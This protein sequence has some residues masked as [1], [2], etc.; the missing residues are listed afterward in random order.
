MSVELP[1]IPRVFLTS[2]D[3]DVSD[4]RLKDLATFATG[5]GPEKKVIARTP[6]YG[7]TRSRARPDGDRVDVPRGRDDH[8]PSVQDEMAQFLY[9]FGIDALFT[10]NPD[11]FPRR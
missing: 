9:T 5:I 3:Q 1:T 6:G 4:A 2:D 7:R 10:N 11:R 8:L